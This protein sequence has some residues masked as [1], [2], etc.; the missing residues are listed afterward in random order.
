ML[1]VRDFEAALKFYRDA[2]GLKGEGESP[3]AEFSS[4]GCKLVLL[5]HGFWK[6]VGGLATPSPRAWKREGIVFAI[7]VKDV[8]H[9]YQRLKASGVAIESPPTDRP[10]MGLRTAQF[11]DP[12]G[13][14]VELT[15]PLKNAGRDMRPPKS[16]HTGRLGRLPSTS[17]PFL[18]NH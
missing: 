4:N 6:T 11:Y 2:I 5:D 10:M 13:N 18:T 12:D 1:I 3:Y 9:D 15:S 14:V 8:D 7:Q 16:R 17:A